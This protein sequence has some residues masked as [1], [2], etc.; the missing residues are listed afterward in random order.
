[1]FIHNATNHDHSKTRL[2]NPDAAVRKQALA[3][4]EHGLRVSAAAGGSG[5]LIVV[6]N[7]EDGPEGPERARDEIRKSVKDRSANGTSASVGRAGRIMRS[8]RRS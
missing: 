5:V 7:A 8:N 3:N 1:M 4:L 2:T 6:G